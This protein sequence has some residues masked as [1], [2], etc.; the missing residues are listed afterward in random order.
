MIHELFQYFPFAGL[1]VR[2]L[3]CQRFRCSSKPNGFC[4]PYL[5]PE[6]FDDSSIDYCG[7]IL[8]EKAMLKKA[9]ALESVSGGR[10]GYQFQIFLLLSIDPADPDPR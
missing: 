1:G 5:L 2:S 8:Y 9:P 3:W 7:N 10:G 6:G 4:C